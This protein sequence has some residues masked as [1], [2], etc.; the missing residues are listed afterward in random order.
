MMMIIL[1]VLGVLAAV[2]LIALLRG[3]VLLGNKMKRQANEIN[4]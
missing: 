2:F 4:T 3:L 1:S